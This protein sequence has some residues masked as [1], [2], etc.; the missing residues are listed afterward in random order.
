MRDAHKRELSEVQTVANQAY[1]N[2]QQQLQTMMAE[3]SVLNGRLES[4]SKLLETQQSQQQELLT[5]VRKLQSE[6]TSLKH[7]NVASDPV[8]LDNGAG[9]QDIQMQMLQMMQDLSKEVQILK[10]D[11]QTDML[12]AQ[13]HKQGNTPSPIAPSPVWSGSAC[14]GIPDNFN[15]AT[16]STK[17]PRDKIREPS[18][19]SGHASHPSI[20]LKPPREPSSPGSSASS[21]TSVG[22]RGGGGGGSSG[23]PGA[24]GFQ[25]GSLNSSLHRSAGVGSGRVELTEKEIYKSK[26]LSLVKIEQ[27]PVNAAQFRSWK[28][29][30]ITK[31]CAID[32]TGED[33]ILSWIAES[34]NVED[35]D[36][37]HNSGILPRLD[38]HL[39]SL[40]ADTRHLKSEIG[41]S[42]QSYIEKCQMAGRS[43]K[44]R[45]M[46]WLLAQQ[47]RLDMQRG[48]N[49]TEQSLLELECESFTYNGL[50]AFIEKIEFVLNAIPFEHQPSE[51]TKFTWLFGRVKKCRMIQR[52]IDRVKDASPD[53]HRRSFD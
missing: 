12:R 30:F 53:S 50:K 14:A 22:N 45:F 28:N 52:N 4:Q 21:S 20:P 3:N 33:V 35:G 29:S 10:Q 40:L 41:M 23:S 51:R 47:F 6:L 31:T 19:N 38:A 44:G 8:V 46:I 37:L 48:A 49:L 9:I 26:D 25:G 39:A 11:R 43:P 34:F 1:Q 15:I 17:F 5:T 2:S 36:Q 16:P 18:S 7:Q 42:Y 24:S 27:L 13:L 32:Q